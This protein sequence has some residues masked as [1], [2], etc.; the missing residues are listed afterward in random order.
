MN[1]AICC[2]PSS[3]TAAATRKLSGCT[4]TWQ[5]SMRTASCRVSRI[6]F[7]SYMNSQVHA[8]IGGQSVCEDTRKLEDGVHFTSGFKDQIYDVYQ[9][10][11]PELL[12]CLI[13]A[14]LPHEILE[15]TSKFM[16]EPA[17]ILLK[18][19]ELTLEGIKQFFVAVEKE[20]RKFDTS[21]DLYDTLTIAQAVF[22]VTQIGR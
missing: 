22:S 7:G 1:V 11:P 16:T 14:M 3:D 13:S 10:L 21:C 5:S 19:D 20:E 18:R 9:Y 17:R 6:D 8:C 4:R 12:V 15:I 2:K